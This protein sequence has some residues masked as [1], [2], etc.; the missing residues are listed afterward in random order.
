M[1]ILYAIQGTGNGHISRAR[2]IIP[3]LQQ[4]HSV[5]ILVSGTQADVDLPYPI[6]YKFNGLSFIFGKSGGVDLFDT[7]KKSNLRKL[8]R[9][10]KELDVDKYDLVL[11]DFEPVSAWACVLKKKQCIAISHQ[12]AVLDA[13]APQPKNFDPVGKIILR[14][15]APASLHYG[16]HFKPYAGNIFN[17]VIRSEVRKEKPVN[18]G[19]YTIYLP[20]YDD[21]RI[22]KML[23]SFPNTK[24]EVFS[25]HNKK[26]LEEKNV[27][28][29]PISN[30]AFIKSMASAEGVLCGAG[31][32]TPAE[33]LFLGKKLLVVP[34]KNQFEQQCNAA[35]LKDMGVPVIKKF[36]KKY[37]SKI[38]E[39][40]ESPDKVRVDYK[41]ETRQIL[42][43]IIKRHA[44]KAAK[45]KLLNY[46]DESFKAFR[47]IAIGGI[48]QQLEADH[49]N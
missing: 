31:F 30:E 19:H 2:E 21:Q 7:F 40:I 34:M 15:Y 32:E 1:K 3:M 29:K 22:I 5:D 9:E 49:E 10:I 13:A 35:A 14:N 43:E 12:S 25:K 39:W 11:N 8:Y 47:K 17:P 37:V 18:N 36:K 41:D 27:V 6:T 38:K 16:F 48:I 23:L 4:E 24:W 44:P 33:A 42:Q 46:K 28:V 20:A 45:R 26:V